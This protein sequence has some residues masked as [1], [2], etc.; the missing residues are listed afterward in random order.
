MRKATANKR[1]VIKWNFTK[2]LE[3]L[4]FAD[5][6]ALPSSKFNDLH[7]KTERLVEE[8]ARVDFK[9]SWRK[10]KTLRTECSSSRENIMMDEFLSAIDPTLPFP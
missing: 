7:E 3:D 8:P 5:D 4:D 2:V 6:I 10:C 1:R 9:L